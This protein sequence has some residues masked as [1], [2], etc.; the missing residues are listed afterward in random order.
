MKTEAFNIRPEITLQEHV[1]ARDASTDTSV[2]QLSFL[3]E[4]N[5]ILNTSSDT[6]TNLTKNQIEISSEEKKF[7]F[8]I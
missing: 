8:F 6:V 3:N 5:K 4:A 1:N 2:N 7:Y